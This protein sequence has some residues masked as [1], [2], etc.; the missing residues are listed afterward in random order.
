MRASLRT[1][2]AR[3]ARAKTPAPPSRV[4]SSRNKA[5]QTLRL[6]EHQLRSPARF[7]RHWRTLFLAA[8]ALAV[9]GSSAAPAFAGPDPAAP[10]LV[11]RKRCMACHTFGKGTKVGPDLKGVT[12]RR[13][14]EWLLKFISSSSSVIEAGDPVAVKLFSE[15]KRE[16]MPD[17]SDLSTEEIGAIVD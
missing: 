1:C 15:F 9:V 16:R 17:W 14:R 11:F 6:P 2:E 10:K 4:N 5:G 12:D 8:L 7:A 3:E 13:K